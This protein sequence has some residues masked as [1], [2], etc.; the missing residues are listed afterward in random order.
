MPRRNCVACGATV[1]W[2]V[3]NEAGYA[4]AVALEVY[5]DASS[6]APRYRITALKPLTV[7]QVSP[8][9]VGDFRVD[10]HFD[11]PGGNAGR[12]R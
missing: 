12:S 6:D 8:G 3:C 10:H 4:R 1:D 9:A 5:T 7:E 2:A 11:C